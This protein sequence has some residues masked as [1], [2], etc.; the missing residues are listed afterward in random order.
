MEQHY[1]S[2]CFGPLEST[3]SNL[4][5]CPIRLGFESELDYRQQAA[6]LTTAQSNERH[7][8]LVYF[9]Q[10]ADRAPFCHH[11]Y[12]VTVV[13]GATP[14]RYSRKFRN[15]QLTDSAL[16]GRLYLN[17]VGTRSR[18]VVEIL[19][20]KPDTSEGTGNAERKGREEEAKFKEHH[21]M[22]SD[23]ELGNILRVELDWRPATPMQR[24]LMQSRALRRWF[25]QLSALENSIPN[26]L[27][28]LQRTLNVNATQ[29][30]AHTSHLLGWTSQLTDLPSKGHTSEQTAASSFTPVEPAGSGQKETGAPLLEAIILTRMET[31]ERQVFC[32]SEVALKTIFQPKP[33]SG[34][35]IASSRV[36]DNAPFT[37][38]NLVLQMCL[39]DIL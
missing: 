5:A 6:R 10:T 13:L 1:L 19:F 11:H 17:M 29:L 32:A 27:N 7:S 34:I 26:V 33:R 14:P 35:L 37:G 38:E 18:T 3:F 2:Q 28:E 22:F 21:A 4:T 31:G 16:N 23:T 25:S 20:K 15:R 39:R 9:L 30:Q 36:N 24:P 8:G 12:H